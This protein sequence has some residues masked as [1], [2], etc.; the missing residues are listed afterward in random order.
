MLQQRCEDQHSVDVS[1]SDSDSDDE[2][3]DIV[4]T[5][6]LVQEAAAMVTTITAELSINDAD[7]NAEIERFIADGYG[8][9]LQEG[10]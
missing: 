9:T 7:H 3:T 10:L 5:E 4:N 2:P 6:D 1:D 8:C